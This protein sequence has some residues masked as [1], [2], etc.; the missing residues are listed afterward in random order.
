MNPENPGKLQSPSLLSRRKGS[1]IALLIPPLFLALLY[2]WLRFAPTEYEEKAEAIRAERDRILEFRLASRPEPPVSLTSPGVSPGEMDRQTTRTQ[3]SV[4]SPEEA[5]YWREAM[6]GLERWQQSFRWGWSD[7]PDVFFVLNAGKWKKMKSPQE[8][9][10]DSVTKT[11]PSESGEWDIQ[12]IQDELRSRLKD[13]Q[14][15]IQSYEKKQKRS[16]VALLK[17]MGSGLRADKRSQSSPEQKDETEVVESWTRMVRIMD[18][19]CREL[20]ENFLSLMGDSQRFNIDRLQTL[21]FC[22]AIRN[23]ESERASRMIEVN[24]LWCGKTLFSRRERGEEKHFFLLYLEM[25]ERYLAQAA[26]SAS[27]PEDVLKWVDATL[28]SWTLTPEEYS[29]LRSDHVNLCREEWI[30]ELRNSLTSGGYYESNGAG[31]KS[32]RSGGYYEMN[33]WHLFLSGI[34]EKVAAK[35]I[36]PLLWRAIDRKTE[37]LVNLDVTGYGEASRLL[38]FVSVGMNL[39]DVFD[40]QAASHLTTGNYSDLLAKDALGYDHEGQPVESPGGIR[41]FLDLNDS[42][43]TLFDRMAWEEKTYVERFNR[44]IALTRFALASARY[45]R[46]YGRYPD[47]VADLIPRYLDDSFAPTSDRLWFIFKSE[48]FT[49]VI[50]PGI[51]D[52]VSSA[53]QVLIRYVDDPRNDGKLPA[54]VEDLKPYLDPGMDTSQFEVYFVRIDECPVYGLMVRND[55]LLDGSVESGREAGTG[56]GGL[57]SGRDSQYLYFPMPLWDPDRVPAAPPQESPSPRPSP[58]SKAGGQ[59]Q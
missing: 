20:P 57:S 37:A 35:A 16:V 12:A 26:A 5:L 14:S 9:S 1:L 52:S 6:N 2:A 46:E 23:G 44:A 21:A 59:K 33:G 10:V 19:N 7:S 54:G 8:D 56:E 18:D 31:R 25:L 45:R 13:P 49:A 42:S 38:K 3:P 40:N 11:F 51:S 53:T 27:I 50:P 17:E 47:S 48:P 32:F 36:E 30:T 39:P 24:T 55:P 28:A 43:H 41:A 15:R 29:V 4:I 58:E 34:P 22:R